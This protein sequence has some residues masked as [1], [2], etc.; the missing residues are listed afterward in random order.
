MVEQNGE[1]P[2]EG[3]AVGVQLGRGH[4]DF[5]QERPLEPRE[6]QAE[7]DLLEDGGV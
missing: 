4:V 5:S 6:R 1:R 7:F 3:L 2:D